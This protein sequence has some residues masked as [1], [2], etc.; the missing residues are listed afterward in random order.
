MKE[1]EKNQVPNRVC[2]SW[3]HHRW[4]RV[5]LIIV[6]LDMIVLGISFALGYDAVLFFAGITG[7]VIRAIIG[8]MYV[9]VA[10][11]ILKE[12][13]SYQKNKSEQDLVCQH[14][15]SKEVTSA[16]S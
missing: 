13:M 3:Y 11:F 2:D 12:T 8:I 4:F 14:C 5:I 7:P 9:L 16:S 1:T 15:L 10:V 6:A